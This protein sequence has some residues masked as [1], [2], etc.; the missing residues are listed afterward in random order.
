MIALESVWSSKVNC[1]GSTGNKKAIR[2][3]VSALVQTV[4]TEISKFT[5][6]QLVA[7]KMSI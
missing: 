5:W 2:A 3:V 4:E 6:S 7:Y 1:K